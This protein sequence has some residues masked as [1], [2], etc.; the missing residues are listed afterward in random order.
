MNCG[1]LGVAF[2]PFFGWACGGGVADDFDEPR[3]GAFSVVEDVAGDAESRVMEEADAESSGVDSGG[4]DLRT[5]VDVPEGA[6]SAGV[7]GTFSSSAENS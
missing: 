1:G 6:S 4:S 5:G 3:E 7:M 2:L